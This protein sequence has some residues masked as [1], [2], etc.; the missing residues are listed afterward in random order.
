MFVVFGSLGFLLEDRVP[1]NWVSAT[2]GE[3]HQVA[4]STHTTTVGRDET[5]PERLV[6]FT[7]C[8]ALECYWDE[9]LRSPLKRRQLVNSMRS[10]ASVSAYAGSLTR[11][12]T[13]PRIS[14]QIVEFFLRGHRSCRVDA[15]TR[16]VGVGRLCGGRFRRGG[17]WRIVAQG[18][19]IRRAR[20]RR[21]ELFPTGIFT[22][23]WMML[24]M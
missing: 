4:T 3:V 1:L 14:V 13:R 5:Q 2:C 21:A 20:C 6:Q 17:R 12:L 10:L 11:L 9:R 7:A 18:R 19:R 23:S 24:P 16:R 8:G 22:V 15:A